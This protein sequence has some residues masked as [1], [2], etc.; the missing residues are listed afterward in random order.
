MSTTLDTR[1]LTRQKAPSFPFKEAAE[2]V[3]PGW[4]V[5][6]AFLG[7]TRAQNMNVALRK[8]DYVPN[9]LSYETGSRSGEIVICLQEAKRQYKKYDMTYPHFV[10]FL[11]IHGCLHL[12]GTQHGTTMESK[13]RAYLARFISTPKKTNGTT[14]RNRH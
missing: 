14:N 5:S 7:E 1:N 9:V 3:L 13:E 2:L 8:K 4:E 11:F 10:G 6:L 12:K